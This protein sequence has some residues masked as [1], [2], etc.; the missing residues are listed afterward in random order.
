MLALK[1]TVLAR[2]QHYKYKKDC[3]LPAL[4]L[5]AGPTA[6]EQL[7]ASGLQQ[8]LFTQIF[9]A[10]GGPKWLAIAGLDKYLFSE[11]FKQRQDPLYTMGASSGAW[12]LSCMAQQDPIAAYER[13]EHFYIH[14]DYQKKPTRE[15]VSAQVLHIVDGILGEQQGADIIANPLIRH[16]MVACRARHLNRIQAKFGLMIGLSMAAVSNVVNRKSLGWHFERVIL[17]HKDDAS[18]FRRLKDLPTKHVELTQDN[19]R[20]GLLASGSIPLLLDPVKDLQGSPKGHYYD[21]GI[22]DYHFDMPL[23]AATGLSL[24]PHFYPYMSPGWF[25]KSLLWRKAK[26]NYHNGL[27]L[28]PSKQFIASLPFSKIPDRED[29]K[30]LDTPTRIAYWQQSVQQS[31]ILAD[32]FAEIVASGTIMDRIERL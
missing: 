22:T 26:A 25:D 20:H 8:S 10:S 14:Q 30:H 12:R 16:H 23:P 5:L 27:I 21:G 9:A 28:A 29:F 18:P 24:Y 17:S 7:E 13:L 4:R 19:I 1:H 2:Y 11:F 6:Y 32:E 31:Q 15:Q 3:T